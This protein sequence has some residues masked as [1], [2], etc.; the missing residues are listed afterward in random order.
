MNL[1]LGP[2]RSLA[3]TRRGVRQALSTILK[4]GVLRLA[5]WILDAFDR[6]G[7]RKEVG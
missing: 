7:L 2:I 1:R 4:E 5:A 3:A 6:L